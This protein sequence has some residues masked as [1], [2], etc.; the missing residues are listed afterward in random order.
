MNPIAFAM[1]RPLSTLMLMVALAGGGVYALYRTRVDIPQLNTAKLYASLDTLGVRAEELKGRVVGKSEASSHPEGEA[2]EGEPKEGE[3]KE[4]EAKEGEAKEGEKEGGHHPGHKVV[5]TTPLQ[6]NVVTTQEYVCQIHSQRHIE[7][8]ALAKGYLEEILLKEGQ[9]VKKG[10]LMF[11]ILPI[12]YQAKWDA[13]LAEAHLAQLEFNNTQ[14]LAAGKLP[15]VS[16]NDVLIHGAKLAKAQ[17]QAALSGAE[18]E[19]T[20]VKAP[21]DGIVDTLREQ[22]GSL[23]NEGDILTTLS[24]NSVMWVYFNVPE[25]RYLEYMAEMGQGKDN[26]DIELELADHHKFPQIGK[27]GAIEAKFD[28]TTGT[29]PFRADFPNPKGLLRHG[30]TGKVVISRALDNAIIIPQRATFETLAKRYVFVVGKDS[31]VHQRE[32]SIQKEL[33][34]VYVID[35]GVDVGEKIILEG[36]RQVHDGEKVAFEEISPEMAMSNMKNHAE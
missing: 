17:A 22:Q 26:P 12:L 30:Q 31:V 16:Q 3:A 23:V 4:G 18:L 2:K 14:K 1:R 10:E 25:K 24:D 19:F 32:V 7:V 36:I 5:V 33:E 27:I 11:K 21:F 20:K 9:A 28:N 8:R 29:V 34:D 13:E 6:K 35:K 15:V